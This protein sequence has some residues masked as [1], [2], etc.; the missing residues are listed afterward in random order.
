M[1][2]SCDLSPSSATKM[3]PKL[4]SSAA[5][6]RSTLGLP[7]PPRNRWIGR[8]YAGGTAKMQSSATLIGVR[9][10]AVDCRAHRP[11]RHNGR[12]SAVLHAQPRRVTGPLRPLE[13]AI[14]AI[15]AGLTV[16]SV[17]IAAVIPLATAAGL[18][19]PVPIALVAA[20]TRLR[21]TIAA[22]ATS[23]AVTFAM[24]GL[25][26]ALGV[27]A[28]AVVGGVVGEV[29][30]RGG[31]TVVMTL[32]SLIVAPLLASVSVLILWVLVP[33]RELALTV[34]ENLI[35]GL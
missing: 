5:N 18:L 12:V 16:V 17:V 35:T 25:G 22:S 30:R 33:L 29:K 6:M 4:R 8:I 1:A 13:I 23:T 21:A 20:R 11:T 28:S 10:T 19:A 26:A 34:L 3:T 32:L 14:V 15:L 7:R 2:M 31:G 9:R 27:L 24:A